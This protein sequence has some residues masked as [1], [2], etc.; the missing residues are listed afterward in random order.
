M[1]LDFFVQ[2]VLL[3]GGALIVFSLACLL[4]VAVW[5][6]ATS[7]PPASTLVSLL[8][9]AI[10]VQCALAAFVMP[11]PDLVVI[12]ALA[13]QFAACYVISYPAM[14]AHS[15][16]LEIARHLSAAGASGISRADLYARLSEASLVS[17][18]IDDLIRDA[19]ASE[20]GGRLR[21]TARGA[22]LARVFG[23][24]KALLGEPKGG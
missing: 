5:R 3:T 12:T 23:R 14:Q 11:W 19:M 15:P 24:W 22:L 1:L 8:S 21:C 16:S 7:I 20:Q 10:L 18:R 2:G 6:R 9:V 4:H 17:D 13:L